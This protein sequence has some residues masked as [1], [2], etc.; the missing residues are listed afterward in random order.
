VAVLLNEKEIEDPVLDGWAVEYRV[1]RE[2][3]RELDVVAGCSA[4]VLDA[5]RG[6]TEGSVADFVAD[7]GRSAALA[8]AEETRA[9]HRLRIACYD[10]EVGVTVE[11]DTPRAGG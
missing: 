10:P 7:R 2:D 4:A 6:V 1:R 8:R 3:G 11:D 9:Y 5:L